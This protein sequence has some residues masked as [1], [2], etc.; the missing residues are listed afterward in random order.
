MIVEH[1][2]HNGVLDSLQIFH[3]L[4]LAHTI[5]GTGAEISDEMLRSPRTNIS[6]SSMV[7]SSKM[8]ATLSRLPVLGRL[9]CRNFASRPLTAFGSN[10]PT[11]AMRSGDNRCST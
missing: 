2:T 7:D 5:T 11:L 8:K 4:L 1:V 3:E 9:C 10:S 6:S